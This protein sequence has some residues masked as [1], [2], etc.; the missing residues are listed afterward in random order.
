[1]EKRE[2]IMTDFEH[3][4]SELRK[5]A[6]QIVLDFMKVSSDCNVDGDGIT[7]AAISRSCNFE[8]GD[9]ENTKSSQQQ[10]WTV[11]LMRDLERDKLVVRD[12]F[13]KRWRLKR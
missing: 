1:M 3:R 11:V 9:Y 4:G 13:T 8:W 5:E 10:Y 12:S 6:K 2:E 7:Q